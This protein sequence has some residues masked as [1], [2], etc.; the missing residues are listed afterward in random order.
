M[1]RLHFA[2][3]A[4]LSLAPLF[5][6][7]QGGRGQGAAATARRVPRASPPL[8][9]APPACR[10]WTATFR[11]TG[12][13]ARA[14]C[15]WRSPRFNSDFLYTT[16]LAAGLGSN[17]HRARS[18]TAGTGQDRQ[19]PARGTARAD[20]A[21][22]R[23]LPLVQHQSGGAPIGGRL[24]REIDS[25]GLHRGR[26]RPTA[27]CWWTP[28]I[29]SS[30]M[31]TAR[32]PRSAARIA[33]TARAARSIMP[34]TKA[35]PKNTE[36]EVTLTFANEAAGGRGG[37]GGG[38]GAGTAADRGDRARARWS[39]AGAQDAARRTSAAGCSPAPW[40]A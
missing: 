13:S 18:R 5:A 40:P 37:G 25:V 20:G 39:P 14:I 16:G 34:R 4:A 31:D 9:N 6:Q 24:V 2:S 27:A 36:I 26:P 30:A 35:F 3:I 19:L 21:G 12:M 10:S 32:R 38:P 8:K 7:Q 11:S 17:D 23:I 33:W 29:S 1:S 22:Q 15:S 28:A